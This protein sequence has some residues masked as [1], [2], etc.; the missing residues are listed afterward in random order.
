MLVRNPARPT[1]GFMFC[2]QCGARLSPHARFCGSCGAAQTPPI[3]A[4]E[5]P[6][7]PRQSASP[8]SPDHGRRSPWSVAKPSSLSP[9]ELSNRRRISKRLGGVFVLIILI[10]IIASAT[11]G[12]GDKRT[13][14]GGKS[15]ASDRAHAGDDI[16]RRSNIFLEQLVVCQE[17][18]GIAIG[19]LQSSTTLSASQEINDAK[20]ACD[21]ALD[22]MYGLDTKH[23]S[24]QAIDGETAVEAYSE[25]LKDLS[26]YIDAQTPSKIVN[27]KQHFETASFEAKQARA[28]IN[29]RRRVYGVRPAK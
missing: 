21:N 29:A 9:S 22:R 15:T 28:E 10:A 8:T 7:F 5:P 11:S 1:V 27:A 17:S 13:S 4:S 3:S 6:A 14:A 26:D 2:S 19:H 23:F 16:A 12:H 25:G 24:D 20:E 18:V